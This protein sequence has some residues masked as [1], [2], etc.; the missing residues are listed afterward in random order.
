MHSENLSKVLVI[1]IGL[2]AA[3]IFIVSIIP[4]ILTMIGSSDMWVFGYPDK[5]NDVNILRDSSLYLDWRI[6]FIHYDHYVTSNIP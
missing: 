5:F 2:M 4:S 6:Y 3:K 1:E